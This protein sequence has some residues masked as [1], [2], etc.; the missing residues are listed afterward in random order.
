MFVGVGASKVRDLFKTAKENA[1]CIVFVDEIDVV[2]RQKGTGIGGGND[3]REKTLNLTEM[4][5]F[6]DIKGRTDIL[7]VHA[8]LANLLN[9]AAILA[10]RRAKTVISS[11]EID[12]S[13]DRIVVGVEGTV[14]T[15]SKS[16]SLVAYDEVGHAVCGTLTAGHDAVQ[17]KETV[18]GDEFQA[19]LSEFTEIPPENRVSASTPTSTPTPV[20]V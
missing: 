6:E 9:E 20:S 11:K 5:G 15:D 13:I 8:D 14:M 10:G 16:K 4:D 12:D 7:E 17:K 18:G 19:I 1:P 2:G 3:E